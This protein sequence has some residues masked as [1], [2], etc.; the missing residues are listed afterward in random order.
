[1]HEHLS[2]EL[3]RAIHKG[4][5]NPGDLAAIAMAHLFELCPHCRREFETWRGELGEGVARDE[6]DYDGALHKIRERT[7][8]N[9]LGPEAEEARVERERREARSRAEELLALPDEQRLDWIRNEKHRHSG[10]L[11]AE[12][13]I[14]ESRQRTPGY[15]HEGYA[16]ADMARVVLHHFPVNDFA[17]ELFIRALAYLANA[18]RVCGDNSRA[19]QLLGD[20]Q[21]LLRARPG[22]DR[23]VQAE[24]DGLQGSLRIEQFRNNEAI[25]ILLRSLMAFE[26]ENDA[27]RTA[28]VLI[29]L[30]RAHLRKRELLRSLA[31]LERAEAL[32]ESQDSPFLMRNARQSK[33]SVLVRLG[34]FEEAREEVRR[35]LE[36]DHQDPLLEL[37]I[38]WLTSRIDAG[39]G[40]IEVAVETM[41][42]VRNGFSERKLPSD[43]ALADL[44]L[45]KFHCLQGRGR[46]ALDLA[47]RAE[48][49][50]VALKIPNALGRVHEV[51]SAA[52]AC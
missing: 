9:D 49:A 35:T 36:L 46:E 34:R 14:E 39:A 13:L 3:F 7:A 41:T 10:L 28:I 2:R 16:L 29:K 44:T 40:D 51:R 38:Q 52:K 12:A 26:M 4:W 48:A 42:D 5:R 19:D 45:A 25:S 18:L 24:I 32:L 8:A 20:A 31:L 37:R 22:R 6:G 11:L 47:D 15:P 43:V 50:L 33:G 21:Y 27:C 1:M 17:V 23:W 30:S